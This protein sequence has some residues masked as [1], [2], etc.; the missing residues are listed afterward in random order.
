MVFSL[1][2][3]LLAAT[4]LATAAASVAVG[5]RVRALD[6]VPEKRVSEAAL[7]VDPPVARAA[8]AGHVMAL[9]DWLWMEVLQDPALTHVLRGTHP[10]LFY[11]LDL[12]TD[13]DPAFAETYTTGAGLLAVVRNDGA[14][15]RDILEKGRRFIER[16]LPSRPAAFRERFWPNPWQVYLYLGYVYIFELEDMVHGA[17]VMAIAA[18]LP[19]APVYLKSLKQRLQAKD[20]Y[21]EVARRLLVFLRDNAGDDRLREQY[22]AKLANL[23]LGLYLH[24]VDDEYRRWTEGPGRRVPAEAR[25]GEFLRRRPE[26]ARD[27]RGGRLQLTPDGKVTSTTP[28]ERVFGLD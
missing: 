19:G 27:P 21:F 17:E 3:W 4:L 23:D 14:G 24:R 13:L 10:R 26:G 12:L 7:R 22:D 18:D 20:G 25:F 6:V 15:A 11:R 8:A 16:E 28:R 5:G 2:N 9:V 1:G